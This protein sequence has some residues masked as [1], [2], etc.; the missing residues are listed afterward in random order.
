MFKKFGSVSSRRVLKCY[1]KG[2]GNSLLL[3]CYCCYLVY[4][5]DRIKMKLVM[6]RDS[7]SSW[8]SR[9]VM[10]TA[11][12]LDHGTAVLLLLGFIIK[13]GVCLFS[14]IIDMRRLNNNVVVSDV[15]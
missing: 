4:Y 14:C 11:A 6:L 5:W 3:C 1:S 8:N 15:S 12:V 10:V 9:L 13:K 7:P 2:V